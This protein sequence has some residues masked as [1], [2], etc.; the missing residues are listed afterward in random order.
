MRDRQPTPAA[1]PLEGKNFDLKEEI[2]AY[3]SD[4]AEKFD[5][6]ASHKIEDKYGLPQWHQFLRK[7][8]DLSPEQT[9]EGKH[10]LDIACGTGEI[11]RVLCSL[12]AKVTG[13]DFSETM[14]GKSRAKLAGQNW[15]PLACDAERLIGVADRQFD[16]AVT[17]HLVWTLTDPQAA[18]AE[19]ARVLK[20][21]GRLLIVDGNW[22]KT[23]RP[24]QRIKNQIADLL[25][26]APMRSANDIAR[27]QKI[28][29]G[30]PYNTRLTAAELTTDLQAA[31]FNHC[32]DLS[33][34]PLYSAGMKAWPLAT[35]L[36]QNA[37]NRFAILCQRNLG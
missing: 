2:R 29:L 12:N 1:S 18:F 4:R 34:K 6:S 23:S 9:L 11:S 19:W 13:L 27:D 22:S 16:F 5:E 32:Q 15:T 3:W 33:V 24:L 14:H 7:A 35:R 8:F 20:P 10:V 25:Q 21:G 26:P 28:R 17:R 30:L 31:G 37:D 36:R